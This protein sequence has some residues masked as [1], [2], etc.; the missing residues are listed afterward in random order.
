M[1][2]MPH[3]QIPRRKRKRDALLKSQIF[4]ESQIGKRIFSHFTNCGSD[5]NA[6][7]VSKCSKRD[8]NIEQFAPVIE[9]T[10]E[11]SNSKRS[12]VLRKSGR[13]SVS[14]RPQPLK[15]PSG[16]LMIC[17]GVS[18]VTDDNLEQRET[19]SSPRV[20]IEEGTVK[21]AK[22]AQSVK[23]QYLIV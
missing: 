13:L 14:R 3:S 10:P 16:I 7:T 9:V 5:N 22:R 11:Y 12:I 1:P 15:R 17:D 2:E 18:N 21:S 4:D 19:T 20:K 8:S 6:S 23:G